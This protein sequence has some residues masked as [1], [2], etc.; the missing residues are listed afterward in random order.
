MNELMNTPSDINDTPSVSATCAVVGTVSPLRLFVEPHGNFNPSFEHASFETSKAQFQIISPISYPELNDDFEQ[1]IKH[2]ES[3]QK[4]AITDGPN[5]S[6]FV[7]W[8][9]KSKALRFSWPLFE[10]RTKQYDVT[11]DEDWTNDYP[12]TEQYKDAFEQII[13]K[14]RISPLAAYDTTQKFIKANDLDL[15]LRHSLVLVHFQLKHYAIRDKKSNSVGT[16]TFTALATQVKIL[17]HGADRRPTAYKSRMLKGPTSLRQSPAKKK[18]QT[19]AVN[20]FHPGD[21]SNP[22]T[23]KR[24]LM[25]SFK[26]AAT[27]S[28]ITTVESQQKH[29]HSKTEGKKRAREEDDE[30]TAT[31]GET[32]IAQ[33]PLTKK[34]KPK[35]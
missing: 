9:S 15:M 26:A 19:E 5:P 32:S 22:A 18:A 24:V 7:V 6:Y 20:V 23:F 14:W 29:E 11:D 13:P 16:N 3:L 4:K 17:E 21:T 31:D 30:G 28:N 10:K 1:G 12:M 2:L 25:L 33:Y 35:K 34:Q 27:N 8:D